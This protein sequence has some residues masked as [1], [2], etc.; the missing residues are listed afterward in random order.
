MKRRRNAWT[1]FRWTPGPGGWASQES[2]VRLDPAQPRSRCSASVLTESLLPR[3]SGWLVFFLAGLAT[4]GCGSFVARRM[5]QSPNSYPQWFGGLA[6]VELAFHKDFLTNFPSRFVDVGPPSARL[7]YR[8]VEPA[9]YRLEVSSTSRLKH[10]REC[11]T[12]N[13]DITIPGLSN[14]WTAS[15]RGTVV[16][17]HGYG[18]AQF[19]MAPWAMHLAQQGWRCVLVDLRGHGEST[20]RRIYFG[21]QETRDLSQLLEAVVCEG[22]LVAPVAVV[23]ESYGAA[24]A[25]RWKA[26]DPHIS[27]VVAIAPYPV[28]SNA[29][30]NI[31]LDYAPCLPTGFVKAGLRNLPAVL[32]V[33]PDQLDP[34]TVLARRPVRALFVAGAGDNIA[35]ATEVQKLYETAATGSELLIVADAT[36]E[37]LPYFFDELAQPVLE[38]LDGHDTDRK[39][40]FRGVY[41]K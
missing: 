28:L 36:H 30:M 19:A 35:P 26:L 22:N 5:A 41:P 37:A 23:G 4:T 25:L 9:D 29:V 8:I 27:Q 1:G 20:G 16:L 32:Q 40:E 24:L 11:L 3:L 34:A 33:N 17:L 13:F 7:Q 14:A 18:L 31:C 15:P 39:V 10:G 6:R 12:F 21:V 38:W 2:A